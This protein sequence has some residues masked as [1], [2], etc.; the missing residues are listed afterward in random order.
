M[1]ELYKMRKRKNYIVYRFQIL[2]IAFL[3]L[4][5]CSTIRFSGK[6]DKS[7]KSNDKYAPNRKFEV[8]ED[9]LSFIDLKEVDVDKDGEKEI[10]AIYN[11]GLNLRGVKVI[12]VNNQVGRNVIFT[13]VFNTNNL[14]L[15]VRQGLLILMV[16]DQ[17]PAGCGLN[18]FYIW[19]GKEFSPEV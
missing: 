10:V 16:K 19:D 14:R 6:S 9:V 1:P 15:K 7:D 11:A 4:C 3:L 17:Y 12:K 8:R 13:K 5:G 18:K 2:F